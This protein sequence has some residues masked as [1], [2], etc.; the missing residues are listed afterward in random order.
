MKEPNNPNKITG[1]VE[2]AIEESTNRK[3]TREFVINEGLRQGDP[4][5][6]TLFNTKKYLWKKHMLKIC[7]SFLEGTNTKYL[8]NIIRNGSNSSR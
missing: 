1:I 7:K 6:P 2:S 3:L 8:E 4:L 5:T